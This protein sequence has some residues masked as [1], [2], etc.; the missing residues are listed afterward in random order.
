MPYIWNLISEKTRE[1]LIKYQDR[2]YHQELNPP[3]PETVKPDPTEQDIRDM[4]KPANDHRL[5][6][7]K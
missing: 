1:K 6:E 3:P 2:K 7:D 5:R 4:A